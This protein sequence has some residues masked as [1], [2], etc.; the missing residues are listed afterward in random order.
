MARC[1]DDTGHV[2]RVPWKDD[3]RDRASD[4]T[5]ENNATSAATTTE[6]R[7]VIVVVSCKAEGDE[8][9]MFSRRQMIRRHC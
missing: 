4:G 6:E 8:L 2:I 9:F 3:D 5:D 7:D 1:D